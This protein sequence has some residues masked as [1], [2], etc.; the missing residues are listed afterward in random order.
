VDQADTQG[1]DVMRERYFAPLMETLSLSEYRSRGEVNYAV[2]SAAAG[3]LRVFFECERDM[4]YF[5][6]GEARAEGSLCGVESLAERFPRVRWMSEG[7]QRLSLDEQSA[8]IVVHW[9]ELQTMFSL[10]HIQETRAWQRAAAVVHMKKYT[11]E[12]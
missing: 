12:T 6:I 9:Q 3:N 2:S 4:C 10:E 5:G 1:F 8:F 11:G 7:H